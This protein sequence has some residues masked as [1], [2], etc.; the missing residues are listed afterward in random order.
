MFDVIKNQL[1]S[2]VKISELLS[3]YG[4]DISRNPTECKNHNSENKQSLGFDDAIGTYN[5]F[6]DGCGFQ[7]DV[8]TLYGLLNN[9]DCHNPSEFVEIIK[10]MCVEYGV[11]FPSDTS[12][13]L[14]KIKS[15]ILNT[16]QLKSSHLIF[17]N[18]CISELFN[19][20]NVLNYII[21]KREYSRDDISSLKLG[22][23]PSSK[24]SDL[25]SLL[26]KHDIPTPIINTYYSLVN[27]II[28]PFIE[29]N[30]PIYFVG[31][32]TK[33]TLPSKES[34]NIIDKYININA[35]YSVYGIKPLFNVDAFKIPHRD[36]LI[37]SE[38]FH[39]TLALQNISIPSVSYGTCKVAPKALDKYGFY[40]R[41]YKK[42]I[43]S[44][45]N[46]EN[47]SGIS[48]ALSL[49]YNLLKF[50]PNIY[51]NILSRGNNKKTDISDILSISESKDFKKDL[52]LNDIINKNISFLDYLSKTIINFSPQEKED[53]LKKILKNVYEL[54]SISKSNILKEIKVIFSITDKVINEY[55]S[56]LFPVSTN[57]QGET[58]SYPTDYYRKDKNGRFIV[59]VAEI[60]DYDFLELTYLKKHPM[61]YDDNKLWWVWDFDSKRWKMVDE[62]S[63]SIKF[64][65]VFNIQSNYYKNNV[66]TVVFNALRDGARK[67]RQLY[68]KDI[69]PSWVVFKDVILDL[70]TDEIFDHSWEYFS[71]NPIPYNYYSEDGKDTP[72]IDT[73]F[74][75]WMNNKDF[76]IL[77]ELIGYSMLSDYPIHRI[78]CFY[79]PGR[80]GKSTFLNILEKTIGEY[81][82]TCT[83]L[84]DLLKRNFESAML[85]KKTACSLAETNF[86]VLSETSLLKRL[87][88]QDSLTAEFKNK[89]KFKFRN[90]AKIIIATNNLPITTDKT[91]GFYSRWIIID[92]PNTYDEQR[93]VLSEIPFV[94]FGNLARKSIDFFKKVYK[95]RK[96]TGESN[97]LDK[98]K[99]Y[100]DK[101]NPLKKFMESNIIE[102]FETNMFLN[103][104]VL[105]FK[106]YLSENGFRQ[107]GRLTIKRQLEHDYGY[108][109]IR[110]N[111]KDFEGTD[112]KADA[113]DGIRFKKLSDENKALSSI[114]HSQKPNLK[115][116]LKD[117]I[118]YKLDEIQAATNSNDYELRE[119]ISFN[120][121]MGF[122]YEPQT[123]VYK[124][125]YN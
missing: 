7:G 68:I 34:S 74:S 97:L 86:N 114:S 66:K 54:D 29:N 85:Y 40:F 99:K 62:T 92:F 25:K 59:D 107:M 91:I 28:I 2:K 100:E 42:I 80:N 46:D 47:Q 75:E 55:I 90:Y 79:G 8:F 32:K 112:K 61:F 95:S 123:G 53:S 6:A 17:L 67:F 76:N 13:D 116:I 49:S 101:S 26:Q 30:H 12:Y 50:T 44:F 5:C 20:S 43:I 98:T 120:K 70:D 118:E 122:L 89:P 111:Y 21:S 73:L 9:L 77:Y 3:K 11:S 121:K 57:S 37:F 15:D 64:T 14:S 10:K 71:V 35:N 19:N 81:N 108:I 78:F 109:I 65:D 119:I 4:I 27:R 105:N 45:D 41:K 16:S 56:T 22:Y 58:T 84:N 94:E 33:F 93:D 63:I 115:D 52:V 23:L 125:D 104:F 18:F 102:D 88:G 51:I 82:V 1:K 69:K 36:Y 38:G 24:F 48:G 124:L 83:D 60:S 117:G 106:S 113:I 39:D 103:E 110:K 96:F 31:E 87:T 72:V